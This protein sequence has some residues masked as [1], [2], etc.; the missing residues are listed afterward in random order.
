MH[1]SSQFNY[2]YKDI[3]SVFKKNESWSQM[4]FYCKAYYKSTHEKKGGV[5]GN[6]SNYGGG[7]NSGYTDT[8]SKPSFLLKEKEKEVYLNG[9]VT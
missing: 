1:P 8:I 9:E 7:P 4:L 6:Q 5:G 2:H 3:V